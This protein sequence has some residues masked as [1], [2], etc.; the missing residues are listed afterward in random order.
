MLPMLS[1]HVVRHVKIIVA[2]TEFCRLIC[3][4]N[5]NWFE[6]VRRIAA[7]KRKQPVCRS[8]CTRLR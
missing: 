8:V 3:R 5:S 6:F 4:A 7:T 2:A 1:V